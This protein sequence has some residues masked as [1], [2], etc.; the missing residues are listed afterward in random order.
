MPIARDNGH[1]TEPTPLGGQ[2]GR[3]FN[4]GGSFRIW[5][6]AA[7]RR[8][9]FARAPGAIAIL[10]AGIA[11]AAAG[12]M[13]ATTGAAAPPAMTVTMPSA[14]AIGATAAP[15]VATAMDPGARRFTGK[16]GAGPKR[17]LAAAGVPERQGREYVALLARAIPLAN[18]LSVDDRFDLVLQRA[19]RREP[20]PAALCRHGP[21]RARRCRAA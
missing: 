5:G 19:R 21:G 16:V 18:G 2:D 15:R 13:R 3:E 20:R 7:R 14:P 10:L 4:A 6:A 12:T 1:G 17:R 9:P 8:G 11:I